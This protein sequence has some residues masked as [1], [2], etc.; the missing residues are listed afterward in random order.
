MLYTIRHITRYAFSRPVFLEPHTVRLQPRS[1]GGQM[2][3][4]FKLSIDPAP[5][6]RTDLLDAEGNVATRCWF[7]GLTPSLTITTHS[8]VETLRSNAFDFLLAAGGTQLPPTYG[9]REA[10]SLAPCLRR[11]HMT[12]GNGEGEGEAG[13]DPVAMLAREV[14]DRAGHDPAQ[15]LTVLTQRLNTD[16]TV[17][18]REEGDPW[19]PT[20]TLRE[21]RGACRDLT[22]L[23]VDICRVMGLAARFVSGY[24]EGDPQQD[25]RDLHAWAE[26]YL[27]G[28]GWRGYD[29]TLGLVVADTHIPL[30]AS[31]TPSGAAPLSGAFRGTGAQA[32]LTHEVHLEAAAAP[33]QAPSQQQQQA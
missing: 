23:F 2:L 17:V 10:A 21:G 1:D 30:A 24:Q 7:N 3:R 22:V 33:S 15:F 8:T 19:T 13:H 14:A 16:L 31:W 6:G 4:R 5:A 28:G 25:R 20:Q 29:P 32:S 26:A 9:K 18:I 12:N 27:P 11:A